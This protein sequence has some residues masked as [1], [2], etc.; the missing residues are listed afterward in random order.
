MTKYRH[1]NKAKKYRSWIAESNFLVIY[2]IAD[3]LLIQEKARW[4]ILQARDKNTNFCSLSA[5]TS[6]IYVKHFSH[7]WSQPCNI[8]S[9]SSYSYRNYVA[10]VFLQKYEVILFITNSQCLVHR[11]LL[12]L[13]NT[14]VSIPSLYI[15]KAM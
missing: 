7:M 3:P 6:Y 15:S 9:F 2:P 5:Y 10:Q 12:G 13:L 1:S 11:K 14:L 8:L 4:L